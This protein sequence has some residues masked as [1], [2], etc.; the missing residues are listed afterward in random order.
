MGFF[1]D[2]RPL[3]AP[4]RPAPAPPMPWLR[5]PAGEYP[6]RLLVRELL[7][8]TERFVVSLSHLDVYRDGVLLAL[9]SVARRSPDDDDLRGRFGPR[10]NQPRMGLQLG[11]GTAV[12]LERPPRPAMT[13]PD[14]WTLQQV[15]GS[16]GGGPEEYRTEFG[17]WLWPLPPSGPI[18]FVLDWPEHGIAEVRT[19]LDGDAIL[20]AVPRVRAL[21]P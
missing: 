10:A 12:V 18:E 2:E 6:E 17:L 7:V 1:P 21:W 15:G 20:D 19:A 5:P 4:P 11:D 3:A 14:G 9:E 16:G 8:Q 13:R